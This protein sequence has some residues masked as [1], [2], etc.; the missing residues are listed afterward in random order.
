MTFLLL[1]CLLQKLLSNSEDLNIQKWAIEESNAEEQ[2]GKL[3]R[4]QVHFFLCK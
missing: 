4:T 1:L 3:H 2:E